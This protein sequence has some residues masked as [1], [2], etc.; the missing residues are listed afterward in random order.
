MSVV[1]GM[2]IVNKKPTKVVTT[3]TTT[4]DKRTIALLRRGRGLKGGLF[5]AKGKHY[6]LAGTDSV[7]RLFTGMIDG[8]GFLCDTFCSCSGRRIV[9]FFRDRKV[10]AGARH[11][12]QMFPISSRSSSIVTTLSATLQKRRIRIFLRAGMG[13]LLLRG[14]SRRGHI[15]NIRLTSRAGVRTSTIVITA[16][17]VSCP[18]AKT[19]KSNCHVTRRDKRGVMS[20]APTLIPVRVGRP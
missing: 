19:A 11:K 12:G 17:K 18:S 1:D 10:P 7:R 2:V 6:G 9:S 16:K 14:E 20:P 8:H 15:A 4:R 3:C 13:H 5:V